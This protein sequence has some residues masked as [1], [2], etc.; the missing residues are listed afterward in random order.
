MGIMIEIGNRVIYADS[1][2]ANPN[3]RTIQFYREKSVLD[4]IPPIR[5]SENMLSD[6]GRKVLTSCQ[7]NQ[8]TSKAQRKEIGI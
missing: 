4:I 3:D 7:G 5:V 2:I 8:Y 6:F 1:Y